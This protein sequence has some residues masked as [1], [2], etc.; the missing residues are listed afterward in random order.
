MESASLVGGLALIDG[1]L[2]DRL[3]ELEL[4]CLGG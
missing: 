3:L 4:S 1:S 2:E